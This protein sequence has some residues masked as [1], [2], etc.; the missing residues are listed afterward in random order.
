MRVFW[1]LLLSLGLFVTARA[2]DAVAGKVVKVLPFLVDQQGRIAKSPSL[3]DR[4]AYQAYLRAHPNLV[5]GIRYDVLWSAKNAG[6][7]KLKLRI[8][9]RGLDTS[10]LPKFKTLE[11]E[12]KPGFFRQ[13]TELTLS[14]EEFKNF[15]SV[16]AWR[17]TL[18]DGDR[19]VAEQKSFLW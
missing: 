11:T 16:T 15:G 14:G 13:W 10:K 7:S 19:Q 6:E 1:I 8:E 3:F 17:A 2:A 12:V 4:D 5:S 9:L 18:W